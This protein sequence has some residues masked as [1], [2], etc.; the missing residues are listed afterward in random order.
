MD[1]RQI[2]KLKRRLQTLKKKMLGLGPFMRGSVVEL[3]ATCGNPNCRCTRGQKHRKYYYSLSRKGKTKIIYLGK[4]REPLA[5]QYSENYKTLLEI[6]DEMTI[7]N[8]ELLKANAVRE[9]D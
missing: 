3:G 6:I 4:S 7:I 5:R 2:Q 8:M 9:L 1:N